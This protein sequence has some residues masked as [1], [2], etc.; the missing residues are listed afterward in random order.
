M[1]PTAAA[2]L[3]PPTVSIFPGSMS[4]VPLPVRLYNLMHFG[5]NGPLSI[6]ALLSVVVP[7][8]LMLGA[9]WLLPGLYVRLKRR[10]A[11]P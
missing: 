11:R 8:V 7:G 2:F 10:L 6:M 3:C 4:V 1:N 5:R 9:G